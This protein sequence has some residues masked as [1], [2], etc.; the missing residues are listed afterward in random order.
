MSSIIV[1]ST[2]WF[3]AYGMI[4]NLQYAANVKDMNHFNNMFPAY[5]ES[6]DQTSYDNL[7]QSFLNKQVQLDRL[8]NDDV[9]INW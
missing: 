8:E 3:N 9:R 6:M 5:F 4:S 2:D 7:Q 1:R